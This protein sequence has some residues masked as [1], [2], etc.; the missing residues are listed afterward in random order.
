MKSYSF[1]NAT[2]S[3]MKF[4]ELSVFYVCNVIENLIHLNSEVVHL[5][6]F[7]FFVFHHTQWFIRWVGGED[8]AQRESYIE[9]H[10]HYPSYRANSRHNKTNKA[11]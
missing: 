2:A 1:C 6:V 5:I 4:L 9:I 8:Q 10:Q 11:R 3:K 7:T